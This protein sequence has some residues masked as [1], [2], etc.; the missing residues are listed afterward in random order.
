MCAADAPLVMNSSHKRT[1]VCVCDPFYRLWCDTWVRT[2]LVAVSLVARGG[3]VL[4]KLRDLRFVPLKNVPLKV[5]DEV[6]LTF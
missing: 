4:Q 3:V 5:K 6:G 2:P 1:C